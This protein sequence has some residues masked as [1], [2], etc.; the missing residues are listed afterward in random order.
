MP[1]VKAVPRQSEDSNSS[2]FDLSYVLCF[3]LL[4]S[5]RCPSVP[6][7]T[8]SRV[9][10]LE[11]HKVRKRG[12]LLC[13]RRHLSIYHNGPPKRRSYSIDRALFLHSC[14]LLSIFGLL[15]PAGPNG[16]TDKRDHASCLGHEGSRGTAA[17]CPVQEVAARLAHCWH[18]N[19]LGTYI[20]AYLSVY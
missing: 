14:L 11:H 9:S 7:N 5:R 16:G 10:N 8:D 20:P 12:L 6:L 18:A 1:T 17:P 4:R 3:Y 19:V 15:A 2:R 13:Q